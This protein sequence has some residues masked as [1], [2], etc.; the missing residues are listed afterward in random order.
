MEERKHSVITDKNFKTEPI[1]ADINSAC[2]KEQI[3][4]L[5]SVYF[6]NAITSSKSVDLANK[7]TGSNSIDSIKPNTGS[8]HVEIANK[9]VKSIIAKH[10]VNAE[11]S[12]NRVNPDE[13]PTLSG[14]EGNFLQFWE[15]W[16]TGDGICNEITIWATFRYLD[17]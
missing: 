9:P 4:D 8:K 7:I 2:Q 17:I 15:I 5:N 13:N 16:G 10:A 11:K 1:I 14:T 6:E 12:E 3:S